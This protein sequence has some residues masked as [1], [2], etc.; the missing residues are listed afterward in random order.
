MTK[1]INFLLESFILDLHTHGGI[2]IGAHETRHGPEHPMYVDLRVCMENQKLMT[3]LSDLF[4]D[5][6][7]KEEI[8]T[9]TYLGEEEID[10]FCGV[11]SG[12]LH[13]ASVLAYRTRKSVTIL[14][15]TEKETFC[16][17]KKKIPKHICLVEDIVSSGMSLNNVARKIKKS[18]PKIRIT[19]VCFLQKFDFVVE[20]I[21]C[22]YSIT[23]MKT[24][25][26][27]MEKHDLISARVAYPLYRFFS[28]LPLPRIFSKQHKKLRDTICT[29]ESK[30]IVALDI[31]NWTDAQKYIHLLGAHVCGFKFHFDLC[32][33]IDYEEL[34][35][36]SSKY[37]F[38]I[39]RDRKYG[40]VAHVN[41]MIQNN[42][43][44]PDMI[45]IVHGFID[46]DNMDESYLVV[47]EMSENN[48]LSGPDY[49]N[50]ILSRTKNEPNVIGYIAQHHWWNSDKICVTPGIKNPEDICTI[51]GLAIIGRSI[52]HSENPLKKLL[53]FESMFQ[54]K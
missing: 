24:V 25:L 38:M 37:N 7:Y 28:P 42:I 33:G 49:R 14:R 53:E 44:I 52:L 11:P 34:Q 20:Y 21:P 40:D 26:S 32:T 30:I 6:F 23:D 29:K 10:T 27:I 36:L 31:P 47:L 5:F 18:F 3:K 43:P 8:D 19:S 41:Q 1:K 2:F 51:E 9:S 50:E 15:D 17:V 35:N 12:S 13:L 54:E 16:G 4:L 22:F 45:H 46:F 48:L 39:F